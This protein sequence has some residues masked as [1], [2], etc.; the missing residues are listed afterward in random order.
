MKKVQLNPVGW[1]S[2]LSQAEVSRLQDATDSELFTMFR[3]CC[4]AVLNSGVDEDN[5]EALFAPYENF[6]IKLIRRER[7]VKIELVNPPEVAFVDENLVRGVHEHLFAVLR[8]LLYMGNKYAFLHQTAPAAGNEITDMVFDML[9]HAKALEGNDGVNTIVCWGGHSINQ[10]EYK[11]TKEV[12]YQLGLRDMNICTG[13]GPGAMKGPMKGAAIGHAKQRH[14]TGRYIGISEPSIIAAEPPNAIVNELIIMPDIEKRLE[15]FVR[16][17]HGIIVFPGGVG[18]A[19][20]LLYMLGILMNERNAQQP[21]PFIL[22]GPAGSEEYFEAIDAFIGATLGQE[23]Q[24]KYQIIVDD[25]EEVARTMSKR[26]EK[27]RKF[28]GAMGDAF[29]FNWSLKIEQDFQKPFIPTHE[30]MA[31]L[32][33]HWEQSKSDLASN[34]RKAFSGIVAG[35]VKA[36]GIAQIKKHG[37]FE[38]TGDSALMNEID[39][40]LKSFVEQHRMKLPGSAYEPCYIVKNK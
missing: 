29:S 19:E 30:T 16:L 33:L 1:M 21:F 24:S 14:K 7:G 12:G 13:C 20:E 39:M 10:V 40:L 32:Q 2:Q 8:D 36:E 3:N 15:A 9:R 31:T 38:L 18:T 27:V 26:L 4:L 17:G 28:R 25:P 23:A 5:F 37:P 22:T 34:L 11:Y 35:N 6:E